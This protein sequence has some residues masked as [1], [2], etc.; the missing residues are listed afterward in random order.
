MCC[1][2]PPAGRLWRMYSLQTGRSFRNCSGISRRGF[3][4]AGSL[5]IAGLSLPELLAAEAASGRTS[6]R[7]VIMIHLDGGPPQMDL[8]DPKPLAPSEYRSPFAAIDT[9]VPGIRLTELMPSCAT[10]A[11]K[12]VFLRSL[13]GADGKHHAFQCQSGYKDTVLRSIG[14]RPALGCVVNHLLGSPEDRVPNFVD[15]MQGRPL[16]RNSARP[17]FLG[18][19]V[20]PFRPDISGRWKRELEEGMKGELARLGTDHKTELSLIDQVPVARL[21][22]R[23]ALLANIDRFNRRLDQSGSMDAMDHF[24]RQAYRILTSGSFARAMDIDQEPPEVLRHYTPPTRTDG[25]Q[26]YTSEGPEAALK[27]LLARRLVEAGVRVVSL[28]LSD[29]DT[30]RDNNARMEDLG[31]LM[32]FSLHALVTD[33]QRLG[34]SNDVLVVAWGE[35][36]RTPVINEKGG[37][38]HWPRLSMGIVAGGGTP[39]GTVL[40]STDKFAGEATDR[41][42]DYSDVVATLYHWL[43]IDLQ[44]VIHDPTGRPHVLM[45]HGNVIRELV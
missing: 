22:D 17:G 26:F 1:P 24:T 40:G 6:S 43:G 7:S 9:N 18:P 5:G 20:K 30:H 10:I 31:P 35:F 33:L 25:T 21:D 39:G 11:D 27:F 29:F 32:D 19:S 15:L 28:S 37:R 2:S 23:L 34:M 45:D 8:I 42:I 41:P 3:L 12:L 44:T 4:T 14:G 36:G 16:V 13:V 38:D